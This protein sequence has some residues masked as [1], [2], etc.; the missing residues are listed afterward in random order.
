VLSHSSWRSYRWLPVW[1][2]S[3]MSVRSTMEGGVMKMRPVEGGLEI[4]AG[5]TVT[6]AP[7]G[8]HVMFR[9]LKHPLEQGKIVKATLKF[10]KAGSVDVEYRILAIG[11]TAPGAASGGGMKM[12]GPGGGMMQMDKH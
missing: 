12:Q 5:E 8:F 6:L 3:T 7:S 2:P 4:K 11:A 1:P 9:D 10:D